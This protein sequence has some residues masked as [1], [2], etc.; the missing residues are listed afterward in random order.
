MTESPLKNL[1][2]YQP[3]P[4]TTSPSS[5]LQRPVYSHLANKPVLVHGLSLTTTRQLRRLRPHL[6][7]VLEHHV[8]VSVESLDAR[9]QLA[10]VP[11]RDQDLRMHAHRGLEDG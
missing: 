8:A 10:V 1:Y 5:A 11:A 7:D 4:S 9:E 6:L 3:R 2:G